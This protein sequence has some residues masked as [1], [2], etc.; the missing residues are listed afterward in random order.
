MNNSEATT[1][2][3]A[4]TKQ[5]E[6]CRAHEI[7]YK[8]S[9][10]YFISTGR[11]DQLEDT[12]KEVL[13]DEVTSEKHGA[14]AMELLNEVD[15]L[16]VSSQIAEAALASARE[17]LNSTRKHHLSQKSKQEEMILSAQKAH[18]SL[19]AKQAELRASLLVAQ[20]DNNALKAA[21][22]KAGKG[23]DPKAAL[24]AQAAHKHASDVVK[25]VQSELESVN[26]QLK[27]VHLEKDAALKILAGKDREIV[28]LSTKVAKMQTTRAAAMADLPIRKVEVSIN[29][30]ALKFLLGDKGLEWVKKAAEIAEADTRDKAYNLL[31][32]LR[33]QK[34]NR[35][36]SGLASILQVAFDWLKTQSHKTRLVLQSWLADLEHDIRTGVLQKLSHYREELERIIGVL[37]VKAAT[38]EKAAREE[39]KKQKAKSFGFFDF[40]EETIAWGR[41]FKVRAVRYSKQGMRWFGRKLNNSATGIKRFFNK[42]FHAAP[43]Q[44][45]SEDF[46]PIVIFDNEEEENLLDS[47][48]PPVGEVDSQGQDG[49]EKSP[50]S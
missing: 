13:N 29:S 30:K 7:E 14:H 47:S 21:E 1:P 27:A 48:S 28:E 26:R 35:V 31:Q 22:K 39:F 17:E 5:L 46:T 34:N 10:G 19:L 50:P 33:S 12:I 44:E 16:R 23:F 15:K 25:D 32:A 20:E 49:G 45:T 18:D 3:V 11:L 41:V 36:V 6:R 4:I 38:A 9:Q 2:M 8:R 24:E 43:G 42:W 40:I 37:K